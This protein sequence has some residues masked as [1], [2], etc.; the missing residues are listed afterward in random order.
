MGEGQRQVLKAGGK[1]CEGR[2]ERHRTGFFAADSAAALGSRANSA[3][4]VQPIG[5]RGR[6]WGVLH[7]LVHPP[8]PAPEGATGQT[9]AGTFA[10]RPPLCRWCPGP[11]QN[12]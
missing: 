2:W 9:R 3:A 7:P 12:T 5:P 6:V 11:G 4:T 10:L 1:M 8:P